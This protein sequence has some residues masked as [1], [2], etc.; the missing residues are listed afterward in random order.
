LDKVRLSSLFAKPGPIRE[1]GITLARQNSIQ[2]PWKA[3]FILVL[4]F[5]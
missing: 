2:L 3:S 4:I 5:I 1:V